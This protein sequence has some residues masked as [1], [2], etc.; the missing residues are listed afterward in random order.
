MIYLKS[1]FAYFA[2]HPKIRLF[3]YQGGIQSTEEAV[4]YAVPLLGIPIICEQFAQ[5][6]KM[7]SL[8]V[9]RKLRFSNMSKETLNASIRDILNDKR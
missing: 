9:A 3:V 7:I 6:N 8:G 2:A 4:H 5:I 1:L